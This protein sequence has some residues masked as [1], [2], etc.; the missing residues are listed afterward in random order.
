MP[1]HVQFDRIEQCGGDSL[2]ACRGRGAPLHGYAIMHSVEESSGTAMGPG[3]IY[4]TLHY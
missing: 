3:P 1:S 2:P 4:G